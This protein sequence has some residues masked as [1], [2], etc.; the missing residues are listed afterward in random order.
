M[1]KYLFESSNFAM[2][3]NEN[4]YSFTWKFDTDQRRSAANFVVKKFN[5]V[6][7]EFELLGDPRLPGEF[8]IKWDYESTKSQYFAYDC[9]L[10]VQVCKEVAVEICKVFNVTRFDIGLGK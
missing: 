1:E 9:T 6:N 4:R 5:M 7:V 3:M 2:K 10:H 8:I